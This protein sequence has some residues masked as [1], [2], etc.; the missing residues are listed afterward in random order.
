M[1]LREVT[2]PLAADAL[3]TTAATVTLRYDQRIRSR[4]LAVTDDGEEIG[5][6]QPRGQTLKTGDRLTSESGDWVVEIRAAAEGVSTATSD[7]P[8][9]LSRAC[10]HLGNRHVALQIGDGFLRYLHDH[11]LDDLVRRL[12]LTVVAECAPFEPESGAYGDYSHH[13][14]AHHHHTD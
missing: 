12:G 7:Q 10:Y 9:A 3:A 6:Y 5:I 4:L 1:T 2:R 8:L 11:V 14:G 13:G